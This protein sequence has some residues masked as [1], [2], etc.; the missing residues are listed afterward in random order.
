MAASG[1]KPII[2]F[3]VPSACWLLTSATATKLSSLLTHGHEVPILRRHNGFNSS[4]SGTLVRYR[5]RSA[6]LGPMILLE[7]N[8]SCFEYQPLPRERPITQ[9]GAKRLPTKFGM[10]HKDAFASCDRKSVTL[11]RYWWDEKRFGRLLHARSCK[12]PHT[13][14][15]DQM[16][17]SSSRAEPIISLFAIFDLANRRA[18]RLQGEQELCVTAKELPPAAARPWHAQVKSRGAHRR[19][20]AASWGRPDD[21]V[22]VNLGVRRTGLRATANVA[23]APLHL[24]SHNADISRETPDHPL[25]ASF[26]IWMGRPHLNLASLTLLPARPLSRVQGGIGSD[27]RHDLISSRMQPSRHCHCLP[28][29]G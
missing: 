22:H 23:R 16:R 3:D 15:V 4:V 27:R 29:Q 12:A 7:Q 11:E 13:G 17:E 6:A 5:D 28:R 9:R 21:H 24:L 10:G 14:S 8:C 26:E 2:C 20:A 18:D 19:Q 1:S 25:A